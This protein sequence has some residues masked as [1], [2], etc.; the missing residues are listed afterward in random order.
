MPVMSFADAQ[1][2]YSDLGFDTLPLRPKGKE[3]LARSWQSRSVNR[4]W[5]NAPQDANIGIR[6]GGLANVAIIDCDDKTRAGTF[7]NVTR[8]LAGLGYQT[9]DYPLVQTQSG[10]GRHIYITFAGNLTGDWRILSSE[11]GA[12]EFRYGAGSYV[13]APPSKTETGGYQLISGDFARLPPL[14]LDDILP[15]IDNKETQREPKPILP[16]KAIAMLNGKALDGYKSKSEAEQALLVSLINVGFTFGDALDLFNRYPCAGKYAEIKSKSAKN[17][18]RWLL[19]SYNEAAQW[20]KTHES[21]DRKTAQAAIAW[22][23]STAWAGRT[24][25]YDQAAYISAAQIAYKAGRLEFTAACRDVAEQAKIGK[26]TASNALARLVNKYRLLEL[27]KKWSGDCGNVYRLKA[28]HAKLGHFLTVVDFRKCPSFAKHD[29]F[30]KGRGKNGLG[31]AAGLVYQT[32]R[33]CESLT[34]DELAKQIGKDKRTIK[35]ALAHMARLIDRKTGEIISMV[36][37]DAGGN[38]WRALDVDLDAVAIIV[39]TA[40][41]TKKQ[42]QLHIKE[43]RD[44]A[45]SLSRNKQGNHKQR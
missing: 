25:S 40:G 38:T 30:R 36:A 44:H 9:G 19:R 5:Q 41:A 6:G 8:W 4:L 42:K 21:Q 27:V 29:A 15:I 22:A 34:V 16:R 18:E 24:G 23:E 3:P 35:R 10:V 28:D 20:A 45:R 2:L 1:A 26:D 43:R 33:D 32:L 14:V 31:L 7:E 17:A 39:G 13:A 12:G 11:I 37:S